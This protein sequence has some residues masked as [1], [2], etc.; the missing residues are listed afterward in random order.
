[1]KR[2]ITLLLAVIITAGAYAA[3]RPAPLPR[4]FGWGAAVGGCIDMTGHDMSSINLDA[5]FGYRNSWINLLGV[6][7]SIDMMVNN[8]VRS[9]PVYAIL[10][11]GFSKRPTL[12]F[13]DF[14]VGC[15]FNNLNDKNHQTRMYVSPGIGVNLATGRTFRSY[16]MLSYIY[17]GMNGFYK[18]GDK[19][20]HSLHMACVRFGV[21]F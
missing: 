11:T 4:G 18:E 5:N 15:V 9:F 17:N 7:A 21:A 13:G 16:L 10:R 19:S 2:I 14:R 1:M 20:I 8:S 6:G 12:C 3:E